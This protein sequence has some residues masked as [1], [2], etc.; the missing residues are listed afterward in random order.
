MAS[1]ITR[2]AWGSRY[3][4]ALAEANGTSLEE[5]IPALESALAA[6]IPRIHAC[7]AEMILPELTNSIVAALFK[8]DPSSDTPSE[9]LEMETSAVELFARMVCNRP[10]NRLD[11]C[12]VREM[13][14]FC[15]GEEGPPGGRRSA[16]VESARSAYGLGG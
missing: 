13:L 1:E 14:W 3:S 5:T 6:V 7:P 4:K 11:E 10:E 2:G 8:G 16:G 12:V 9:R 15:L